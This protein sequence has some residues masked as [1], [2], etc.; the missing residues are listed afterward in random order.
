MQLLARETVEG[1][2][3]GLHKSPHKGFSVEFK[4]HRAYS[5]GDDVR[6]VDWKLYG[7]TDRYF[8]R[9]HEEETNLRCVIAVDGSG[10][11]AYRG[12]RAIASKHG[13]AVRAAAGLAYLLV[14]QQDGVGLITFDTAIRDRLPVRGT[15]RHLSA[16]L[17]ALDR[18]V[19]NGETGL[20]DVVHQLASVVSGRG[21]TVLFSD[22]FGD[23][24]PLMSG[25]SRLRHAGQEVVIVQTLDPDE[26]DFPFR[27]WT[28]F[29]S[30]EDRDRRD[31]IDP[32]AIRDRY[33]SELR[34]FRAA[35]SEGCGRR[36][37]S[38]VTVTTDRPPSDVLAELLAARRRP[39]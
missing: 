15:P 37:I 25:L 19:S 26:L 21:L 5:P 17:E 1:F 34:R 2:C 20:G 33:L 23:V 18:D 31:S 30:L 32:A 11:M 27:R 29:R 13:F 28:E 36:K 10:S 3:S 35:L 38:L 14:R 8:I 7:K 12:S 4:E 16:I 24:E 6:S 9:E 22:L 39:T